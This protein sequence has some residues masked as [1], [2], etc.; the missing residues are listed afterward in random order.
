M[1]AP[2]RADD[3]ATR[4]AWAAYCYAAAGLPLA[5]RETEQGVPIFPPGIARSPN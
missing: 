3:P 4:E 5:I 1:S 2:D